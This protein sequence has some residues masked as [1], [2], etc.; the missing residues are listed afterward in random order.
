MARAGPGA[1]VGDGSGYGGAGTGDR[2]V[3]GAAFRGCAPSFGRRGEA[4][5]FGKVLRDVWEYGAEALNADAG[6]SI[7]INGVNG[8]EEIVCS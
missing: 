6:Q 3:S 4:F 1:Y 7:R 8:T 5:I 2:H